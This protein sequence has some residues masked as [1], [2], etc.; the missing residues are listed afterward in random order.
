M[1]NLQN[2]MNDMQP[3]AT[4]NHSTEKIFIQKDLKTCSHVFLLDD[5]VQPPLKT[6]YD[7]P[8]E[9]IGR[10][11]KHFDIKVGGKTIRVSIDRVKTAHMANEDNSG[12]KIKMD[13]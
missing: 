7:G 3:V 4:S 13:L 11:D 1:K 10:S 8:F 12:K 2:L 5:S 9:V 6:P